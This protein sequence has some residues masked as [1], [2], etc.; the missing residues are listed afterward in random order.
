MDNKYQWEEN[1][2]RFLEGEVD[3]P[4]YL[5]HPDAREF[6]HKLNTYHVDFNTLKPIVKA[7]LLDK[8]F[9]S[10]QDN[11]IAG[12]LGHLQYMV[13]SGSHSYG[14]ATEDSDI[15][16]RGWYFPDTSEILKLGGNLEGEKVFSESDSTIYSFHKFIRLCA[17]CNP[18]IIELLGVP[19]E[20]IIYESD[21]GKLIRTY[22]D[23]FLSKRAFNTFGGYATQQLR[24]LQNAMA[25]D[26][27]IDVDKVNH[28]NRKKDITKLY[29][30][31]MHLI[32]LYYTVIDILKEYRVQTYR[33]KEHE[34]LMAIRNGEMSFSDIFQ[35]QQTL[36]KELQ[37]AKDESKLPDHPDMKLINDIIIDMTED[38][39]VD[40]S[41][42]CTHWLKFKAFKEAQLMNE[43]ELKI[44]F[45][46]EEARVLQ[47]E[48]N[49]EVSKKMRY[50]YENKVWSNVYKDDMCANIE[51]DIILVARTQMTRKVRLLK[52]DK[53]YSKQLSRYVTYDELIAELKKAGYTITED[54]KNFYVSF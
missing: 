20:A 8:K 30:H 10:L 7:V 29:K 49:A 53:Y 44:D 33:E 11:M 48:E 35:R 42:Y 38:Y 46:A 21:T 40:P 15:D 41:K 39:L 27:S 51:Y 23:L 13:I 43:K 28:R 47:L 24:K 14:T 18:N 26:G 37:K 22:T 16:V 6:D 34:L 31:A 3:Y 25:E 19:E 52:F 12:P 36:E 45:T 54:D 4:T 9:N 2:K 50:D 1:R 32:R 17:A 5:F